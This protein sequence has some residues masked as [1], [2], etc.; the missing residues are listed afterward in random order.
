MHTLE[1]TYNLLCR[2]ESKAEGDAQDAADGG[3]VSDD[4]STS[5][6]LVSDD[7]EEGLPTEADAEALADADADME[8]EYLFFWQ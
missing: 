3:D 7:E 6:W 2:K 1:S 8:G 5:S 4:A